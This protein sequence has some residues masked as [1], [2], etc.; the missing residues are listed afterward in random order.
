MD[1]LKE[2]VFPC[3]R[4]HFGGE[5]CTLQQDSAPAHKASVAQEWC[6]TA[7]PRLHHIRGIPLLL[8]RLKS[9]QLFLTEAL[10]SKGLGQPL[11]R[12]LRASGCVS[13]SYR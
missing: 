7:S 1:I 11:L 9:S 10:P 12:Y 8:T 5:R 2:V 3:S 4:Y 13:E 6:S